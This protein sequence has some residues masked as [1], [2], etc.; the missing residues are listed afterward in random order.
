M[1]EIIKLSEVN[2]FTTKDVYVGDQ[3]QLSLKDNPS[4]GYTWKIICI[5]EKILVQVGEKEFIADGPKI[6]SKG[7]SIYTFNALK[8]GC[9]KLQL[10]YSRPWQKSE[11]DKDFSIEFKIIDKE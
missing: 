8:S 2:A 9:T 6:G 5:D 10:E 7:I 3:I 11:K 1:S 4:T